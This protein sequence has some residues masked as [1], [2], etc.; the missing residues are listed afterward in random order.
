MY[1]NEN[2]CYLRVQGQF[3]LN[4]S[5]ST[6]LGAT[7]PTGYRPLSPDT[8]PSHPTMNSNV[9]IEG[10][11]VQFFHAGGTSGT[12]LAVACSFTYPRGY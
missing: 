2:T 5:G 11:T 1:A 3:S 12:S 8:R 10:S 7:L 4:N 6:S 9:Y